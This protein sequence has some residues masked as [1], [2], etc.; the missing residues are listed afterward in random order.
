MALN[1]NETA[2][3]NELT[4]KPAAQRTPAENAELAS[5]TTKRNS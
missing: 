1:A 2:R 4:A 5:L 3:F